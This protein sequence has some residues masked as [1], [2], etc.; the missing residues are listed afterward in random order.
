VCVAVLFCPSD[1]PLVDNVTAVPMSYM[2]YERS[3]V[4]RS[5]L[6]HNIA[7]IVEAGYRRSLLG[8]LALEQPRATRLIG[9]S[10]TICCVT[11]D[12]GD[13]HLSISACL[14]TFPLSE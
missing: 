6:S 12:S 9:K 11:L 5:I 3:S 7:L 10:D 13:I 4:P 1:D 14:S 8:S 2:S